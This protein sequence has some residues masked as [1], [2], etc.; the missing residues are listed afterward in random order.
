MMKKALFLCIA[1]FSFMAYS[2]K[3]EAANLADI[4]GI[5]DNE[6]D[7]DLDLNLFSNN[8]SGN[9]SGNTGTPTTGG[10]TTPPPAPTTVNNYFG[11][12]SYNY[13]TGPTFNFFPGTGG[14]TGV[15]T[16]T[17]PNG[18]PFYNPIILIFPIS[19]NGNIIVINITFSNGPV[20]VASGAF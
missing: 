13:F 20:S 17:F 5:L 7:I 12:V 10:G 8:N 19:G 6:L 16:P 9:N 15:P 18:T 14:G 4:L 11:P 3:S 1:T 2:E